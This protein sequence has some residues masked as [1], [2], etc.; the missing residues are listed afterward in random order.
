MISRTKRKKKKPTG[1]PTP[2]ENPDAVP[3]FVDPEWDDTEGVE[4]ELREQYGH[5]DE[6][7]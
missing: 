3:S 4:E 7:D 2:F 1:Y 5:R 6:A